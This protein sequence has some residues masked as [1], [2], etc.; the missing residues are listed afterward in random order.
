MYCPKAKADKGGTAGINSTIALAVADMNSLLSVSLVKAGTTQCK[1]NLVGTGE[2]TGFDAKGD[3][4][5]GLNKV[6]TDTTTLALRNTKKADL[7][8]I[9]IGG[10]LNS[11]GAVGVAMLMPSIAGNPGAAFGCT[12][13]SVLISYHTFAHECGHNLGC[14]HCWDQP[15]AGVFSYSHGH[16]WTGTD[17][18]R[19]RSALSYDKGGDLR[20]GHYSNPSVKFKGTA[21]GDATKGDNAR[22][23]SQTIPVASKYK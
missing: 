23:L 3:V 19:Y 12:H 5:A 17:G 6:S 4:M 18:K 14:A 7:V 13:H 10:T 20:I 22:S 8:H 16:R 15:G 9:V 11:S 21:S 2:I 1:V